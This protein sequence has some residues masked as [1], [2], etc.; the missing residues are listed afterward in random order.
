[1]DGFYTIAVRLI[2]ILGVLSALVGLFIF[3]SCRCFPAWKPASKLMNNAK[4]KRF[5]KS[6]CN[7]W[8][9]FWLLVIVHGVIALLYFFT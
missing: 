6:H 7:I 1:M 8:W 4:Y 9:V 5:F 3:L 2:V